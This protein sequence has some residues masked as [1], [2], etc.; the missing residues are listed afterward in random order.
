MGE[1]LRE[2]S[3]ETGSASQATGGTWREGVAA[4]VAGSV[5]GVSLLPCLVD[6]F[7]VVDRLLSGGEADVLLVA[8]GAGERWVVKQ[9]RQPGW[10]PAE[11]VLSLLEGLKAGRSRRSWASDERT[12]RCV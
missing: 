9:Y 5:A 12:L 11:D 1:T 4:G 7:V 6:R 3:G 10:S 8:D 2:G